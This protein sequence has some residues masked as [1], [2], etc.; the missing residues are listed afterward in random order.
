[1]AK[2]TIGDVAKLAG[3][4]VPTIRFYEEIGLIPPPKRT[5]SNRRTYDDVTISRLKFIRH[6]RELGFQVDAIRELLDIAADHDRS[7]SG[8]DAIALRH[9]EDITSK[10]ERLTALRAEIADMV[11]QCAHGRVSHCGVIEALADDTHTHARYPLQV[12]GD[13]T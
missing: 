4:K 1:M 6:A 12:G 11:A 10:I 5:Q 13:A 9:L 8:A 2:R 7:C 3:V